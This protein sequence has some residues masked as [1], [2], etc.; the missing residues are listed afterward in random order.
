MPTA[1]PRRCDDIDFQ[2]D[3]DLQP[4]PANSLRVTCVHVL[5]A[6]EPLDFALLSIP[7]DQIARRG[8]RR[9]VLPLAT[10]GASSGEDVYVIHHPAG[11]AKKVSLGCQAFPTATN[12]LEHTCST[13]GGSS[14]SPVIGQ[15]GAVVGLHFAGAYPEDWTIKEI[16]DALAR[17]TVFRNRSRPIQLLRDRLRAFLP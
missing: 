16:N 9:T 11:L 17:G 7:A 12:L 3:F 4:S 5:D 8:A 10:A 2:F 6:D 1:Q 15:N 13:V 14:G